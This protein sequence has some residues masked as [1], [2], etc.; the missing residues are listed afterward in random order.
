MTKPEFYDHK[1][2]GHRGRSNVVMTHLT[3]NLTH[4]QSMFC[5]RK[6]G[7]DPEISRVALALV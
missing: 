3:C 2:N 6:A 1:I 5:A 7:L 4:V